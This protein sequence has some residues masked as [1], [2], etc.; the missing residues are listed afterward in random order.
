ML[1]ISRRIPLL[2]DDSLHPTEA[3]S[4][5]DDVG[6][7]DGV[8]AGW[9]PA[10]RVRRIHDYTHFEAP[11]KMSLVAGL[12][13]ASFALTALLL[14]TEQLWWTLVPFVAATLVSLVAFAG[15]F[16]PE[17]IE[18]DVVGRRLLRVPHRGAT[19]TLAFDD[20]THLE[21]LGQPGEV[22][23]LLAAPSGLTIYRSRH[24]QRA[25]RVGRKLS[26]LLGV[27]LQNE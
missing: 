16:P 14:D 5:H 13:W 26:K 4:H 11:W 21:L 23:T 9:V 8:A 17:R 6:V 7:E 24:P 3:A 19:F 27:P 12:A 15:W 10:G 22:Q 18:L 1:K 20:I 25:E 2:R